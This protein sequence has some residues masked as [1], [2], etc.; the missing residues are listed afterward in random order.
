MTSLDLRLKK[1]MKR[2]NLLEEIKHNELMSKKR[3]KT[4]RYLNYVE[5]LLILTLT[6]TGCVSV[7]EFVS[8]VGSPVGIASS[9]VE[10]RI[11][12]IT[13]EIK[14]HQSFIKKK[15]EEQE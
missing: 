9:S 11:S 7:L 8:L 10:L 5:H 1:W 3:K 12:V 14:K 4:Y 13:A 2:E 6:V 15:K